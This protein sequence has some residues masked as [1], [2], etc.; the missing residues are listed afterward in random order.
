LTPPED[1]SR[2]RRVVIFMIPWFVCKRA[3]RLTKK[4]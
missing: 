3:D 1:A 2:E 4:L